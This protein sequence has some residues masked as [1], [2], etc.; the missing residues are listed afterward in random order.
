MVTIFSSQYGETTG[1]GQRDLIIHMENG[2]TYLFRVITGFIGLFLFGG[3]S[4]IGTVVSSIGLSY[5][6]PQLARVGL[7]LGLMG[8]LICAGLIVWRM[9]FW[10]AQISGG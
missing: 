2:L 8:L 1:D 5:E 4:A 3:S 6:R 7:A 10:S 9:A